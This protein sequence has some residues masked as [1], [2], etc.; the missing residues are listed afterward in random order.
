MK[1]TSFTG[2]LIM[3]K[4]LK[5]SFAFVIVVMLFIVSSF[6]RGNILK[7]NDANVQDT[8]VVFQD[9]KYS[10]NP[11]LLIQMNLTGDLFK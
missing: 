4:S 10:G 2:D 6:Y 1:R 9:G 5:N 8:L 3:M 7:A 11:G